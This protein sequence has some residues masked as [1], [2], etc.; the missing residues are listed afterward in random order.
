MGLDAAMLRATECRVEDLAA[1]VSEHTRL[2]DYPLADRVEANVL[3][4]AAE[5]LRAA[6]RDAALDELARALG[7][8]P[9][10]V[11]IEGAMD[12][13]TVDRAT[14]VF[15]G[16]IDEQNAAGRS[17]GDHFA[18]PVAQWKTGGPFCHVRQPSSTRA[19]PASQQR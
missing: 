1:V 16:I 17:V 4:Y 3:V 12:P 14:E 13:S 2:S 10:V 18:K 5:A 8:G 11:I 7:D 6:D 19:K 9:G 15:F